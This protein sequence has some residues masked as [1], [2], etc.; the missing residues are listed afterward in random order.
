MLIFGSLSRR[1]LS[2]E[3]RNQKI[4]PHDLC[5]PNHICT[6]FVNEE[7]VLK[8]RRRKWQIPLALNDLDLS[9][10]PSYEIPG[11]SFVFSA[12]WG[13]SRYWPVVSGGVK[14]YYVRI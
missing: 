1:H 8:E 14:R 4:D 7:S 3:V 2:F 5:D 6:E 10:R 11:R 12:V 9:A 13:P